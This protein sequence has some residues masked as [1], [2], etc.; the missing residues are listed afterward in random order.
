[1]FFDYATQY[2]LKHASIESADK[3]RLSDSE[4]QDFVKWLEGKDFDYTT[5]SE[6]E[7]EELKKIAS[8][9]KYIDKIKK[10][11]DA[12]KSSLAHNKTEDL[13]LFK[14]E[15]KQ[16]LEREIVSRYYFQKGKIQHA[17]SLDEE[18]KKAVEILSDKEQYTNILTGKYTE[19]D[20]KEY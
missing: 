14:S 9:E 6:K 11:Y 3:F 18:V 1:M 17:I 7:L 5:E 15:I 13:Q 10:E 2:R 4:Y 8:K 12:L 20:F 16:L 19:K